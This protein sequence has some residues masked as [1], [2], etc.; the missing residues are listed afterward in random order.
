MDPNYPSS[1]AA[2]EQAGAARA[3]ALASVPGSSSAPTPVEMP[4]SRTDQMALLFQVTHRN[5]QGLAT[6]VKNQERLER[7]V[8]T[9][10]HDL[11]VKMT[12]LSIDFV[13]PKAAFDAHD[14][15]RSDDPDERT[16]TQFQTQSRAVA[17]LAV[18]TPPVMT[19][20][21]EAAFVDALISTPLTHTGAASQRNSSLGA[22]DCHASSDA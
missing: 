1:T 7:I 21:A 14:Y 11:D 4:K 13:K 17:P 20:S 16:T 3:A 8:E 19:T 22:M 9:K 15:I 5:E 10:F 18:T 12:K 6:L 2:Q